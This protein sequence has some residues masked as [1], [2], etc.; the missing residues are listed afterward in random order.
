MQRRPR[1]VT[2]KKDLDEFVISDDDSDNDDEHVVK[3]LKEEAF[4]PKRGNR[5]S[6][7]TLIVDKKPILDLEEFYVREVGSNSGGGAETP[8]EVIA[9][10]DLP[11]PPHLD[12]LI[13][14][15]YTTKTFDP[16]NPSISSKVDTNNQ[17]IKINPK[18][19]LFSNNIIYR[20]SLSKDH[21]DQELKVTKA[22]VK[23]KVPRVVT[24]SLTGI[25][26]PSFHYITTRRGKVKRVY[27]TVISF[28]YNYRSKTLDEVIFDI[29]LGF[30]LTFSSSLGA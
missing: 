15:P 13:F 14:Y 10:K 21:K 23:I 22:T 27:E 1:A 26:A 12:N 18:W 7:Q 11:L 4:K 6:K 19:V 20:S 3:E 8:K 25:S 5:K 28:T 9:A 17:K 2:A 29:A 30:S 24:T 16:Y